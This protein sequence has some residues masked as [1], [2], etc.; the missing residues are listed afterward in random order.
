MSRKSTGRPVGRPRKEVNEGVI[1]A[2]AK[3]GCTAAEIAAE[4]QVSQDT[5]E[6]NFADTLKRGRDLARLS[7]RRMQWRAAQNGSN[8]MLVWLGKQLLGQKDSPLDINAKINHQL[9][10]LSDDEL[11]S[12]L[13]TRGS[14][15]GDA[16]TVEETGGAGK[17]H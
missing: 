12:L 5:V 13:G 2:L 1:L 3:V 15:R 17:A 9:E 6:R 8:T 10:E 14:D 7:L 11:L 16:G 4:V